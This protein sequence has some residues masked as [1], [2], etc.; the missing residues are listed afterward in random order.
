[1]LNHDST[2]DHTIWQLRRDDTHDVE[3]EVSLCTFSKAE[4]IFRH[5]GGS[6][7]NDFQT[8]SGG[9]LAKSQAFDVLLE[10]VRDP[11]CFQFH[12]SDTK[13]RI[14]ILDT[15]LDPSHSDWQHGRT[16]RFDA[17]GKPEHDEHDPKQQNR[18]M[19]YKNF[20]KDLDPNEITDVDGHGTQVAGIILR[21]AH[22]AE[23]Y[24]A[25]VCNEKKDGIEPQAVVDA[26]TW[27]IEKKVHLINMSCGF[28]R[29]NDKSRLSCGKLRKPN[30]LLRE[31]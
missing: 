20:V 3:L 11:A 27:A 12:K 8:S 14:A 31:S 16:L 5:V 1:M 10:T 9:E 23:I 17:T 18:I 30:R 15:G 2:F 19:A 26:I 6:M 21:L 25:R 28:P 4:T 29:S 24:V 13:V 7:T 22:R